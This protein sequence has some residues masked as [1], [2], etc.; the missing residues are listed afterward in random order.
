MHNYNHY[1]RLVNGAIENINYPKQPAKLY[2]PIA[3]TMALG[4]KRVRPVLTL[5]TCEAMG[6]DLQKAINP[7]LGIEL[8]HNYTLVHDDVMDR[9]DLRRG[10]PT[11]HTRWDN[12]VAI[13]CGDAMLTMATQAMSCVD[14]DI[15]APIME[16]FNETA[17]KIYEGQQ[18]DMDYELRNDVTVDEYMKMIRLKTSVLLGCSCKVGAIVARTDKENAD[19]IYDMAVNLGIAFQ[20]QDDYLDVWGDP[21]TFGKEIGGDIVNNKKTFL[22]IN[23]IHQAGG[24]D[25]KAL[26]HWLSESNAPKQEKIQGVTALYE[27]LGIKDQ[28]RNAIVNYSHKALDLLHETKMSYDAYKVFESIIN[29]L[30]DRD[31]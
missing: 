29:Q 8:F 27:K 3:Y 17:M 22:L 6:G 9:A 2:E 4:G 28:A 14:D 24:N 16:V 19:K 5:M 23:A 12:N 13:L 15:V 18:Y 25:A 31:H 7:A 1:L 21:A 11:V 20:L 30:A 10:K 26:K